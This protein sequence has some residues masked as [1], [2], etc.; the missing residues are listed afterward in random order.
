MEESSDKC[1]DLQHVV[2]NISTVECVGNLH[3]QGME[4]YP[5]ATREPPQIGGAS[6]ACMP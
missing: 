6:L 2:N 3:Q 1:L 5:Q 4:E